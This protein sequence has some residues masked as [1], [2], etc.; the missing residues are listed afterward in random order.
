M[1]SPILWHTLPPEAVLKKLGS[2]ADGLT[3]AEAVKR[4]RIQG[5]NQLRGAKRRSLV[6]MFFSQFRDFMIWVLLCAAAVSA[7]APVIAG[8]GPEWTDAAIILTVVV[9][10]AILGT[11]QESRA[12]AALEALRKMAVPTARVRRGGSVAR[13]EA[14]SLVRGDVILLE[15]G[16]SIPADVRFLEA[17]ALRVDEAAL[18]GESVPAEKNEAACGAGAALGDRLCMGYM[19]TAVVAGRGVAVVVETAMDT[20]MGSIAEKLSEAAPEDTPLQKKLTQ[21]SNTLSLGILAVAAAVFGLTMFMI[22][23]PAGENAALYAFMVA[24]SLA[25]SAIPEGMV[26]VVTIVLALGMR[27]MAGRGAII[28]RLPAVET[29][30]ST[31]VICSDKTGTLTQN[32]MT[33]TDVCAVRETLLWEAMAHCN[34]AAPDAKG[35]LAGDPTETALLEY[36]I[37]HGHQTAQGLSARRRAG[38]VPFDSVR[39]LSSVAVRQGGRLR[40]YTKG[41]PD[42]LL[43]RCL[44]SPSERAGAERRN[45]EMAS[46]ALRVLAFGYKDVDA[47]DFGDPGSVESGL[48]YL[49]LA[50]MRDPARPEARA[51]VDACRKA[52]ILPV[53]I[54]GDHKATAE[55]IANELGILGSDRRTIVTGAELERMS[56][57]ELGARVEN[58]AVYARVSPDHKHRIVTAWQRRGRITAMTGDGVNDA[59]ALKAADI[60]VGMGISGND[61]SR[62]ASDMVLT[63]DNFST[64][65]FAVREGRRIYDNIHKT[66]RFLLSSNA[67]EV[68]A[69]LTATLLGWK[70]LL[71][72]HILWINL[73]TDTF[74][75]LALGAEPEEPDVMGRP[76]RD[77]ARP[78]FTTRDWARI[79]LTGAA[80][81]A[82]TLAAFLLGGGM[83]NPGQATAMAFMTLSL[84]QLFAAVSLQ[85][86]RHSVFDIRLRE[87]KPLVAA[88]I[89]SAVLQ[90]SVIVIA[91]LRE[92]FAL[93]PISVLGWIQVTALCFMMLLFIE[94]QKWLA[95]ALNR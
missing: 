18:T 43:K 93:S 48:T 88:F 79:V 21:I 70:L 73:V 30:G 55:A 74:P 80:E 77:P 13:L 40:I 64:I 38:E 4:L 68:L 59:P 76:A 51:A 86:E 92:A 58:I 9:M 62:A 31:Q 66:V 63:D 14:S 49:G 72:V 33:V 34:D 17:V 32:R 41:A 28:R 61:V 53:M 16:D 25:V 8:E 54:T 47:A 1:S 57:A 52:G 44:L 26:A 91:P 12:E 69:V 6:S 36:L 95:R 67:G 37:A 82:L 15:A 94:A 71:P 5:Y 89:G 39:K 85:S 84:S 46:G 81:A 2:R 87:H 45:Q 56:D 60:G 27:K 90:L 50:G 75:A 83:E 7:L 20:Q 19:G 23:P 42:V 65:V 11:I 3:G 10:N 35:K 78:F 29:L 22:T 24:V